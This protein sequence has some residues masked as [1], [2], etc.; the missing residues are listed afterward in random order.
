MLTTL[1]TQRTAGALG[2]VSLAA[3][4]ALAVSIVFF[5]RAIIAAGI[6]YNFVDCSVVTVALFAVAVVCGLNARRTGAGMVALVGGLAL[7]VLFA[8]FVGLVLVAF[9]NPS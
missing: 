8:G 3:G 7:G 2:C 4:V 6:P 1:R 9:A 5:E